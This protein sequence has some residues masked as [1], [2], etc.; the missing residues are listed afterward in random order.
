M[1]RFYYEDT[2][3]KLK[4]IKK[5]RTWLDSLFDQTPYQEISYIFCS[6]EYLLKINQEYLNHD[7]YTDIITFPLELDP[8][9]SNIF[10]SIDRVKDN[11]KERNIPFLDE[12]RRVMAHGVLHLMG[13]QD[14][15]EKEKTAMRKAE[16]KAIA[17]FH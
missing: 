15:T 14:K 2:K 5:H 9:E 7:N 4:Q 17:N 10:I 16:D 11:A 12:L 8:I 6:D 1:I 3:F 13:L